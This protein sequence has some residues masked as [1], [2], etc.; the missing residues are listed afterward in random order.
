MTTRLLLAG[1]ILILNLPLLPSQSA[2]S[3]PQAVPMQ[4]LLV[5]RDVPGDI[6]ALYVTEQ[7]DRIVVTLDGGSTPDGGAV[8][9]PNT[10]IPRPLKDL[11]IQAWVL[12]SDGTTLPQKSKGGGSISNAG[13][14]TDTMTLVFS[15]AAPAD[16]AAVVVRADGKFF[17]REIKSSQ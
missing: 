16:L 11:G 5:T 10:P 4:Y 14:T 15:H 17:V 2:P 1:L 8:V 12:R 3:A 13:W 6:T 7:P 9:T